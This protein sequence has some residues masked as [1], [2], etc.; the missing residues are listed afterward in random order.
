[1]GEGWGEG[2]CDARSEEAGGLPP[3]PSQW[4]RGGVRAA[5]G[6]GRLNL[7]L[8]GS[9]WVPSPSLSRCGRRGEILTRAG[10]PLPPRGGGLGR[11]G[12]IPRPLWLLAAAV[13]LSA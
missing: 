5:T 1:M 13:L 10:H 7:S 6:R 9:S 4:E 2:R 3:R 12:L 11:G 8:A